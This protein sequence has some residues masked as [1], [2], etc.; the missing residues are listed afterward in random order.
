MGGA[1]GGP[2]TAGDGAGAEVGG[3][4][5]GDA[6]R[7]DEAFVVGDMTVDAGGEEESA[8]GEAAGL[9]GPKDSPEGVTPR[10]SPPLAWEEQFSGENASGLPPL[11]AAVLVEMPQRFRRYC[12]L[13]SSKVSKGGGGELEVAPPPGAAAAAA[14]DPRAAGGEIGCLSEEGVKLDVSV[15]RTP[16]V[17]TPPASP[18]TSVCGNRGSSGD[19]KAAPVATPPGRLGEGNSSI[20]PLL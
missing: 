13:N 15:G 14:R 6:A 4:S 2:A 16:I 9:L 5:S 11:A 20:A 3:A 1:G 12:P 19:A 8:D 7:G 18:S 17:S 10:P